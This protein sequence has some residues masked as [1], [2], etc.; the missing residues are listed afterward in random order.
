MSWMANVCHLSPALRPAIRPAQTG[1]LMWSWNFSFWHENQIDMLLWA[2]FRGRPGCY[3]RLKPHRRILRN[4]AALRHVTYVSHPRYETQGLWYLGL[5]NGI[6]EWMLFASFK[7]ILQKNT[8]R[9]RGWIPFT[10]MH[11]RQSSLLRGIMRTMDSKASA[12][13]P[14]FRIWF[15]K[16]RRLRQVSTCW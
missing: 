5:G 2:M 12:I 3:K 4:V 1:L 13:L 10:R 15:K 16:P 9:F 7:T 14:R 11:T 6:C 8:N